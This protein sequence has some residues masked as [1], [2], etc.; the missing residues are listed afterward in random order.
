VA[1][2]FSPGSLDFVLCNGVLG[3]GLDDR[4]Q[5]ARAFNGF[6]NV[7]RPGGLFLLGWNDVPDHRP[8]EPVEVVKESGFISYTFDPLNG[9]HFLTNTENRHTFDFFIKAEASTSL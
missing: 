4:E 3:W 5:V 8:F 1:N 9:S 6:F 2:H 7:L